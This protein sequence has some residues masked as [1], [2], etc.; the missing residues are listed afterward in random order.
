MCIQN[1]SCE[2]SIF[3]HNNLKICDKST[4]LKI[5]PEKLTNR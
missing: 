4:L 3:T 1:Y 2:H 5:A